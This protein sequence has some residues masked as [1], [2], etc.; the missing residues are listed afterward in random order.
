MVTIGCN[1]A[2]SRCNCLDGRAADDPTPTPVV[3]FRISY[4]HISAQVAPRGDTPASSFMADALRDTSTPPP[5]YISLLSFEKTLLE[6]IAVVDPPIR[7]FIH[8]LRNDGAATRFLPQ[9][10]AARS[11]QDAILNLRQDL[12]DAIKEERSAPE[13]RSGLVPS[14]QRR[15]A[16]YRVFLETLS[17]SR[18]HSNQGRATTFDEYNHLFRNRL[19][20][21][22]DL[23]RYL[24]L[25]HRN[26][27]IKD[28]DLQYWKIVGAM[29]LRFPAEMERWTTNVPLPF[30]F[31]RRPGM[32]Q[33]WQVVRMYINHLM[34]GN[35]GLSL[36][37]LWSS[38]LHSTLGQRIWEEKR[39]EYKR[40][41]NGLERL[42]RRI[43]EIEPGSDDDDDN[44]SDGST[45]SSDDDQS[46]NG[47]RPPGPSADQII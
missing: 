21:A 42:V 20:A 11:V 37:D 32:F 25:A 13:P 9:W 43:Q 18:R 14:V 45:D 6:T 7:D 36:F 41:R 27:R 5:I 39:E 28:D 33:I 44:W 15:E 40:S 10:A 38:P 8:D 24:K 17:E 31:E 47:V 22:E 4:Q 12:F 30:G 1:R 35:N 23:S 46:N 16:C 19:M 34:D 3:K 29:T 2:Q 26:V